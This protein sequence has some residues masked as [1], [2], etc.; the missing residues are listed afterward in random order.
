MNKPSNSQ[1]SVEEL[2]AIAEIEATTNILKLIVR[3]TGLRFAA[4][5][6]FCEN[7]WVACSVND[8]ICLGIKDRENFP[9][10]YSMC[11]NLLADPSNLVV[12]CVSQSPAHKGNVA[13]QRYGF[14]SSISI[15]IFLRDN[16][17]FGSLCVLDPEANRLEEREAID[18]LVIFAKLVGSIFQ[19]H[20]DHA[21]VHRH[22]EADMV[23]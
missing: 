16:S 5:V 17:L 20:Y 2:N 3:L 12:G 21:N 14:E 11:S 23:V 9:L 13:S 4:I 6:K 19:W 15:P 22:A 10:E 1:L 18:V 7:D 8:E